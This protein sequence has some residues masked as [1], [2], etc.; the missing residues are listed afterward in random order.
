VELPAGSYIFSAKAPGYAD[1]TDRV[2]IAA[3]ES[4]TI[5]VALTARPTTPVAIKNG[6]ITDFE[7]AG[8]WKKDGELWVHKGGGFVPYKLGP[9]GVYTFTVELLKGGGL[10]R[11]GRIRWAA[12]Y[13]DSK[14]YLSYELDRK[15]FWAYVVEKGKKLERQKTPLQLDNG[16]TFTIQIEITPDH[17]VHKL[18]TGDAAWL[19]LDS[20]A[21]PGRNFTAGK[22][23]FLIQGSDEI[24]IS[25]FTFNPK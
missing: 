20:F 14:D 25:D 1:R 8:A 19:T 21:E 7:E 15:T 4:R 16:K 17:V 3:G 24:G 23:G 18:K 13:I 11:G 22:F 5:E 2:Q 9:R 10:F 12:Q 6:D